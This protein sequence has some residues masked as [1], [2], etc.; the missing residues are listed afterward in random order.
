VK[1]LRT[2]LEGLFFTAAAGGAV[3][4]SAYF[5]ADP[6]TATSASALSASTLALLLAGTATGGALGNFTYD[7]ARSASDQMVERLS[8]GGANGTLPLNHD[9]ARALRLSQIRAVEAIAHRIVDSLKPT[10]EDRSAQSLIER[11]DRFL[12]A[13]L[14]WRRSAEEDIKT[15]WLENSSREEIEA[16]ARDVRALL[17]PTSHRS[18]PGPGSR[19]PVGCSPDAADSAACVDAIWERSGLLVLAELNDFP[20]FDRPPLFDEVLSGRAD[21]ENVTWANAAIG[22]FA[23]TLKSDPTVYRI[24]SVDLLRDI[25]ADI[26]KLSFEVRAQGRGVLSAIQ[27]RLGPIGEALAHVDARLAQLAGNDQ[28]LSAKLDRILA[29]LASVPIVEAEARLE[30]WVASEYADRGYT[31]ARVRDLIKENTKFFVGREADLSLL[32]GFVASRERGLLIVAAPAGVGKSALLAEWM[33]R[34]QEKRDFVAR[35]IIARRA[36]ETVGTMGVLEHLLQQLRAYRSATGTTLPGTDS[37]LRNEIFEHLR[38]PARKAERL[39]V[40]IDGLDEADAPLPPFAHHEMGSGVYV[41]LGVRTEVNTE[42]EVLKRWL[43]GGLG[44]LPQMRHDMKPMTTDDI[45]LWLRAAVSGARFLDEREIAG[46]LQRTTDGVPLFL[47]FVVED[48]VRRLGVSGG[49]EAR[50]ALSALPAPFTEYVSAELDELVA[51]RDGPWSE[52][53]RLFAI[54][55]QTFGSISARELHNSNLLP[56]ELDLMRLDH[57]IERWFSIS[58][59][60]A[61]RAFAFAHPRLAEVFGE[62]LGFYAEDARKELIEHCET[63]FQHWG[64][65][66]LAYAP[67]HL[68]AEGQREGWPKHAVERAAKPLLSFAFHQARLKLPIADDLMLR[69]PR[70]LRILA[71]RADAIG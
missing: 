28:E 63:W 20:V 67:D 53:R 8:H 25:G 9:I 56:R 5:G 35:H 40:L 42:P 48:F 50:A 69:V 58:G 3:M 13:I 7:K 21:I 64:A 30:R 1:S 2:V 24:V 14:K 23:E 70:Q 61:D 34:R 36:A 59:S 62:V 17:G 33:R 51:L 26:T 11:L 54:L 18:P 45:V 15:R 12:E 46:A 43:R 19:H 44:D 10:E 71:E 6:A 47:R 65:Y 31:A 16:V 38:I 32:D 27:A 41:V 49:E 4:A 60:G 55:T 68:L 22:F 39:I 29:V 52:T 57:R 66:A 37:A